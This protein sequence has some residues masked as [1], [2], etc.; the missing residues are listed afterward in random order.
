MAGGL[1]CGAA[2][3]ACSG[4]LQPYWPALRAFVF[5]SPRVDLDRISGK[6]L[7][8]LPVKK[9]SKCRTRTRRAHHALKPPGLLACPKCGSSKL[10][11]SACENCGFVSAKVSL[12][13]QTEEA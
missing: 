10:P 8:M 4:G 12:P 6:G 1:H 5:L 2:D 11:H 7:I 3:Q 13:T 9:I